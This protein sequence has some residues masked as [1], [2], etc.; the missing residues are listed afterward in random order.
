MALVD[1]HKIADKQ[2]PRS[3]KRHVFQ[4]ADPKLGPQEQEETVRRPARFPEEAR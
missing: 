2:H 1:Q 3:D 4:E